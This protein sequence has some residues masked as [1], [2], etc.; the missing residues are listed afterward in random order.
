MINN[1]RNYFNKKILLK[2][3]FYIYPLIMLMPSGYITAYVTFLTIYSFNFFYEN[4]IKINFFF[5]DYLIFA[6]LLLSMLSTM[7]NVVKL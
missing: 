5:L 2:I 4:K 3:L 1:L 7:I 6:I